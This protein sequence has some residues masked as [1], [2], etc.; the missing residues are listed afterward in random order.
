ML[1]AGWAMPMNLD[2]WNILCISVSLGLLK[3]EGWPVWPILVQFLKETNQGNHVRYSWKDE[4][5]LNTSFKRGLLQLMFGIPPRDLLFH[6][7]KHCLSF[8]L[9]PNQLWLVLFLSENSWGTMSQHN[10][11]KVHSACVWRLPTRMGPHLGPAVRLKAADQGVLVHAQRRARFHFHLVLP[12]NGGKKTPSWS[13]LLTNIPSSWQNSPFLA[14]KAGWVSVNIVAGLTDF[15]TSNGLISGVPRKTPSPR[16]KQ[17]EA[18]KF[19]RGIHF[20]PSAVNKRPL[21]HI[22]R[23]TIIVGVLYSLQTSNKNQNFSRTPILVDPRFGFLPLLWAPIFLPFPSRPRFS[24]FG[25]EPRASRRRRSG[26][27]WWS[28]RRWLWPGSTCKSPRSWSSR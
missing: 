6:P 28:R 4:D 20:T 7:G 12:Q 26:G 21:W 22:K 8:A 1:P 27:W 14:C 10:Q 23:T 18:Y 13:G 2:W 3:M 11:R 5:W 17:M 16:N 15:C 19:I 25:S 9:S 24:A